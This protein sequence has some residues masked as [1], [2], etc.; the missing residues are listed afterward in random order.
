MDKDKGTVIKC[1]DEKYPDKFKTRIELSNIEMV[2]SFRNM[3]VKVR[4][5]VN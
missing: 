5:S 1:L 2:M 4:F 3:G